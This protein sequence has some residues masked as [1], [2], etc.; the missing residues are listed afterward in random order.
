MMAERA[1]FYIEKVRY[2]QGHNKI[3]WVSVREDSGTKL[4]GAY[5]M[6]RKKM[7]HLMG[8]GKQFMTIFRNPEGKYRR[9]Q[10]LSAVKVKGITYLRTDLEAVENDLLDNVQEY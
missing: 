8:E 1:D 2:D 6:V 3:I 7:M 4:S 9:G 5:N 10:K